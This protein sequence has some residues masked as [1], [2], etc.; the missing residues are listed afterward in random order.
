MI[1][2]FTAWHPLYHCSSSAYNSLTT[3]YNFDKRVIYNLTRF[4]T[5]W[6][7][8][9]PTSTSRTS[10]APRPRQTKWNKATSKISLWHID[11]FSVSLKF[12]A[13]YSRT[14]CMRVTKGQ[15]T[16]NK[17][18]LAVCYFF[19]SV[20][21]L[22]FINVVRIK[23]WL[24]KIWRIEHRHT[25]KQLSPYANRNNNRFNVPFTALMF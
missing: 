7:S 1:Q 25:G 11:F 12:R 15:R 5:F 3:M 8:A 22:L 6:C 17:S 10:A 4:M 9:F 19:T 24:L 21:S 23:K 16:P 2:R 20:R 13:F 14:S 18:N